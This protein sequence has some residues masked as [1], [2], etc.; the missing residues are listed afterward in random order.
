MPNDFMGV[1]SSEATVTPTPDAPTET[2]QDTTTVS[3][4]GEGTS[5]ANASISTPKQ[6]LTATQAE[7]DSVGMKNL[8][9]HADSLKKDLDRYKPIYEEVDRWGGLDSVKPL[10]EFH[11]TF[12]S[13]TPEEYRESGVYQTLTSLYESN[14]VNFGVIVEAIAENYP[15]IVKDALS[16]T[17]ANY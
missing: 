6:S 16:R 2:G 5:E 3:N 7:K 17:D 11:N 4:Y 13:Q 15:E 14:P 9:A 8:R 12:V 1:A 10:V